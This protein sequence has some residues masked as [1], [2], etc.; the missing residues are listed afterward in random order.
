VKSQDEKKPAAHLREEVA[1]A[2]LQCPD[3]PFG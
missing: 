2:G 3:H 1:R